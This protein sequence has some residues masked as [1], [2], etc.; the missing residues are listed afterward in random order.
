[1]FRQV[2]RQKRREEDVLYFVH[3]AGFRRRTQPLNSTLTTHHDEK[4][5]PVAGG[6]RLMPPMTTGHDT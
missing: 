4:L 5:T 6:T 1:M 2:S 3:H